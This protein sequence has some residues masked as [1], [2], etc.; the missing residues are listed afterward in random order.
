MINI[1]K[2]P[3][4][5]LIIP[6]GN[7]RYAI[8]NKINLLEAYEKASEIATKCVEWLLK[9]F[10]I[11]IFSAYS[12]SLDNVLKRTPGELK[13]IYRIQVA[14]YKRWLEGSLLNEQKIKVK[15]I[16]EISLLPEYYQEIIK[17]IE[18]ETKSNTDHY[19]NLLCA[20]SGKLEILKAAQKFFAE[21]TNLNF[22]SIENFFKFLEVPKPVDLVIRTGK[23]KRLS[24][25]LIFQ[26]GYSE[27]HFINKLFP[28]LTKEDIRSALEDYVNRE[29]KRGR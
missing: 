6:D 20:Y 28:E 15:F 17:R 25:C 10:N 8:K 27:L 12:I 24:D 9:D 14:T 26:T 22:G 13:P 21:N 1:P 23:E 7:R 16:G 19:L 3:Q 4:H 5:V 18:D 29:I 2:L 11:K